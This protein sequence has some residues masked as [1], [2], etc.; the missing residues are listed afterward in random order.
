[1][2]QLEDLEA[3]VLAMN[4][5]LGCVFDDPDHDD[6]ALLATEVLDLPDLELL[7]P[8]GELGDELLTSLLPDDELDENSVDAMG[9]EEEKEGLTVSIDDPSTLTSEVKETELAARELKFL[10]AQ[11]DFLQ[12]KA[13]AKVV[14]VES[15]N[16][17]QRAIKQEVKKEKSRLEEARAQ[18][19]MLVDV[20]KL[21]QQSAGDLHR[22][23]IQASPLMH[24][25]SCGC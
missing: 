12:Y 9:S 23:M 5:E 6:H 2:E 21:H 11:R 17:Q 7:L 20:I 8:S 19:N 13:D 24:Y 14:D 3:D 10:E 18:Q 25:V 15:E 4:P 1:M 22:L 16:E